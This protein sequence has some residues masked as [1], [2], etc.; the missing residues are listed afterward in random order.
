VTPIRCSLRHT[1]RQGRCNPSPGTTNMNLSGSPAW[2]DTSSAAPVLD[3]LRTRQLMVPP[4]TNLI[5]AVFETR[6][7][8]ALRLSTIRLRYAKILKEFINHSKAACRSRCGT[9]P[10]SG[11]DRPAESFTCSPEPWRSSPLITST[12]ME[13]GN[14]QSRIKPHG[15]TPGRLFACPAGAM[16]ASHAVAQDRPGGPRQPAVPGLTGGGF[17]ES[18]RGYRRSQP[19]SSI[20]RSIDG[21]ASRNRQAGEGG[22]CSAGLPRCFPT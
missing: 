16:V 13:L 19:A 22:E 5:V 10:C 18:S 15:V 17:S 7:R 21:D 9:H 6:R 11:A 3:R 2:L 20:A 14:W 1:V 12:A 4:P 8:D